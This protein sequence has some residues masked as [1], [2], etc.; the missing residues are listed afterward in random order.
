MLDALKL[1]EDKDA[2]LATVA[3]RSLMRALEGGCSVPIGVET[4]WVAPG[5]LRL[6]ATVVSVQGTEGVDGEAVEAIASAEDAD[7]FGEK[8]AADLVSKGA[9]KILDDIN[10]NKPAPPA[11]AK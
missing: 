7:R 5:Q 6:R 10:K 4:K 11:P 3:E 1:I 8:M 9:N 2:A